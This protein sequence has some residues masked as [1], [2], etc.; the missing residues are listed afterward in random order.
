[1]CWTINSANSATFQMELQFLQI[2][3]SLNN[4]M[5]SG[6]KY[7]RKKLS[8]FAQER[9]SDRKHGLYTNFYWLPS[10][11]E[12]LQA[13]ILRLMRFETA[14]PIS[15]A[16]LLMTSKADK[17]PLETESTTTTTTL[18]LYL[19]DHKTLQSVV[20][21]NNTILTLKPGY[22]TSVAPCSPDS[23]SKNIA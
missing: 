1:M 13:Q 8:T 15:R 12:S 4:N 11:E 23:R 20:R 3:R 2:S 17:L 16:L 14:F 7:W 6:L 18:A 19:H 10:R 22:Q 21:D 5:L 9:F